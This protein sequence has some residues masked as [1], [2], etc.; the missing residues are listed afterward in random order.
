M[1]L[2]I[3]LQKLPLQETVIQFQLFY[4]W[5]QRSMSTFPWMVWWWLLYPLIPIRTLAV[6]HRRFITDVLARSMWDLWLT[7]WNCDSLFFQ[8]LL[9][10]TVSII[11][12]M[13]LTHIYHRRCRWWFS[14]KNQ[15]FGKW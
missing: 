13:L 14:R 5:Q 1:K 15:N 12:S 6:R 3:Y 10:P 7:K 11:P 4:F 9:F 8:V 2:N